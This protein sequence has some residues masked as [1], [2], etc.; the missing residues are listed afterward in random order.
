VI[1]PKWQ[2]RRNSYYPD[3]DPGNAH[4]ANRCRNTTGPCNLET[5]ACK[6]TD[7]PNCLCTNENETNCMVSVINDYTTGFNHSQYNFAAVW[8]RGRWYLFS[9]SFISDVQECG[10][11][12]RIGR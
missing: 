2:V 8:L 11:E 4:Q 7:K 5:D 1:D 3:I 12:L 10:L 9:N 6:N